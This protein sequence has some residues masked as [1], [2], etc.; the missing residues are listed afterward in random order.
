MRSC[1]TACNLFFCCSRQGTPSTDPPQ[2]YSTLIFLSPE[3]LIPVDWGGLQ[4]V[5]AWK[6]GLMRGL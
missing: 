4:A 1:C 2:D 5:R 6:M 3:G